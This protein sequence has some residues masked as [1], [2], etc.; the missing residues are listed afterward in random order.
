MEIFGSDFI[1]GTFRLSD[2]GMILASFDMGGSVEDSLGMSRS[3]VEAFLGDSPVPVYLGEGYT[4][5]LR[6]QVTFVKNPKMYKG[7]KMYFSEKECRN[8]FRTL[9]GIQGYEWMKVINPEDEDDIWYRGKINDV[10]VKRVNGMV[11]GIILM[12]ECDSCLGWSNET[13]IHLSFLANQPIRIHSNTDDLCHYIYPH[14]TIKAKN[15]GTLRLTNHTDNYT[16]EIKNVKANE[17]I[18]LDSKH[19]LISSSLVHPLLLNDFNLHWV[20]LLPDENELSINMD[21]V[22]SFVYRVPRKAV[23]L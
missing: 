15:P 10:N 1:L 16:T 11:V 8:I 5:K 20:R 7:S 21:A 12:M 18:I 3:T 19:E 23:L 14:V 17:E 6:P 22:I 4:D 9:T 2:Y 13:K